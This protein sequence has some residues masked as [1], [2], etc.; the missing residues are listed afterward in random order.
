MCLS[1]VYLMLYSYIYLTCMIKSP[2]CSCLTRLY[3][4]TT[5]RQEVKVKASELSSLVPRLSPQKRGELGES[6]VT[7]RGKVVDF[8]RLGLAYQSDCRTKPRV[9]VTFC[10][11]SKKLSTWRLV[12]NS[13]QMCTREASPESPRSKLAVVGCRT[14]SLTILCS[15]EFTCTKCVTELNTTADAPKT[16]KIVNSLCCYQV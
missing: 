12:K 10:P 9:H 13:F 8:R 5:S 4:W 1:S 3:L 7:F 2:L 14:D 6:L 16:N 11:L 15:S